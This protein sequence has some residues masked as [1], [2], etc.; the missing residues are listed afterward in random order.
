MQKEKLG[1]IKYFSLCPFNMNSISLYDGKISRV[2]RFPNSFCAPMIAF[3]SPFAFCQGSHLRKS[4]RKKKS[5][6]IAAISL[7]LFSPLWGLESDLDYRK[8]KFKSDHL[9]NWA[10]WGYRFLEHTLFSY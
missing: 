2:S 10:S 7:C 1:N 6:I 4:V 5:L 3:T 8:L 9:Q